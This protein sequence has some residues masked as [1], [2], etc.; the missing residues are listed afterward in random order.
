MPEVIFGNFVVD[1]LMI[2]VVFGSMV[3]DELK[4]KVEFWIL[5]VVKVGLDVVFVNLVVQELL[6]YDWFVIYTLLWTWFIIAEVELAMVDFDVDVMGVLVKVLVAVGVDVEVETVWVDPT[7]AVDT[8]WFVVDVAF[9]VSDVVEF[10]TFPAVV[11]TV[12]V[13]VVDDV[14]IIGELN[15]VDVPVDDTI[16][17]LVSVNCSFERVV[18][19]YSV[20]VRQLTMPTMDPCLTTRKEVMFSIPTMLCFKH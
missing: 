5:T 2:D 19:T 11:E 18:S 16:S 8:C 13:V 17:I 12:V 6:K 7:L 20:E 4:V 14:D 10:W 3:V 9:W 15:D 1:M